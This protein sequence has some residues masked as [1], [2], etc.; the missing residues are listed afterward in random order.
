MFNADKDKT[1]FY[2]F[3]FDDML[4]LTKPRKKVKRK[5]TGPEDKLV[6]EPLYKSKKQILDSNTQQYLVHKQVS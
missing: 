4:L 3:L 5:N 2:L 6:V 1:E